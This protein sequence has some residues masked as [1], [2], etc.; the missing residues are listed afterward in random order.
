MIV[1]F[2]AF[3]TASFDDGLG[4][5]GGAAV[6]DVGADHWSILFR[7]IRCSC[8]GLEEPEERWALLSCG[9]HGFGRFMVCRLGLSAVSYRVSSSRLTPE[10]IGCLVGWDGG[11]SGSILGRHFGYLKSRGSTLDLLIIDLIDH[12]IIAFTSSLESKW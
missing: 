8:G 10:F 11:H 4:F 3:T 12:S 6:D 5:G 7:S 2:A 9:R 1:G